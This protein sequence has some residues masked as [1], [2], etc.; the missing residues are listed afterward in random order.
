MARKR[1]IKKI[2]KKLSGLA[3][4]MSRLEDEMRKVARATDT[5]TRKAPV[6]KRT[7]AR[8]STAKGA[9]TARKSTGKRARSAGGRAL[10][11]LPS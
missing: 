3:K 11:G 4:S 7:T 5:R 6:A 10:S 9:A 1:R 8:K 2:E